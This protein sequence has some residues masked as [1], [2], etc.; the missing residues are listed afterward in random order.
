MRKAEKLPGAL[1]LHCLLKYGMSKIYDVCI[2]G[3]GAVGRVLAL[4]LA[5]ERLKVALVAPAEVARPADIRA[6]A[7][8][9]ASRHLLDS[10]RVWPDPLFATSISAMQV[11]GDDGGKLEFS[12]QAASQ[13]ALAW[14]VDVAH[15]EAKLLQACNYQSLIETVQEPCAAPL[16]IVCE[17]QKSSAR[18]K[19][20]VLWSVKPYAQK[21]IAAR[22]TSSQPHG[23][24]ARQWFA[25]DGEVLALLPMGGSSGSS[26]ALVW[27]VHEDHAALLANMAP[28]EFCKAVFDAT[29]AS[30]GALQLTS[31]QASWPLGVGS[32]EK[33]TGAGWALAG[34]AA[35]SV[36]PLAGQGLNLGLAD[37]ACLASV[38]AGREYWRSLGDEKL[39]RR[40]ER[41]R[42]ADVA[43]VSAVTDGLQNLFAQSAAPVQ[44]VRNWGMNGLAASQPLKNWLVSRAAGITL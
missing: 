40:Y 31:G 44:A 11:W 8:N 19:L 15:I 1:I 14:I 43:A 36:H 4:L 18:N 39:L 22:L 33:W 5:K 34:D 3:D 17:G 28:D 35:H 21:A 30:A 29:Q 37:A 6:Y 2:Q 7:L 20:G 24:H 38:L 41:S 23:G 9:S 27:S 16:T 13:D 26:L 10:L 32:A 25:G 12:A 42:K